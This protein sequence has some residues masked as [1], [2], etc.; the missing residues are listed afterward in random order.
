MVALV[1][2]I[3]A[4]VAAAAVLALVGGVPALAESRAPEPFGKPVYLAL[5]DS[6]A[7][8]AGA[9]PFVSGYPEQTGA[10]LEQ[11]YNVAADKATP[12]ATNDFDVVNY[13]VGGATT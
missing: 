10:L 9:Q 13:A 7:A 8:G 6:V 5:G 4:A 1:I 2:S 12:H 11:E 3:P